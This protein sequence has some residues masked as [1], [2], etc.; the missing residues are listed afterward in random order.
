M[1]QQ[2]NEAPVKTLS[3]VEVKKDF[4]QEPRARILDEDLMKYGYLPTEDGSLIQ[5]TEDE[6]NDLNPNDFIWEDYRVAKQV[7]DTHTD[8]VYVVTY[9]G[10]EPCY[11]SEGWH[12]ADRI[13]YYLT[14]R[15]VMEKN[16]RVNLEY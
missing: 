6:L 7:V 11:L 13:G 10:G 8:Q 5:A 1:L 2:A 3:E 12:L 14:S 16:E 4:G 15:P 9:H